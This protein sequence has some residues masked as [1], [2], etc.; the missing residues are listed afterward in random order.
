MFINGCTFDNNT[1]NFGGAIRYG[2]AG[3]LAV[4]NT[5]FSANT[6]TAAGGAMQ[7]SIVA[8]PA[9]LSDTVVS[10]HTK[11]QQ[12]VNAVQLM[13]IAMVNTVN[14]VLLN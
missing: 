5:E 8:K 3:T 13:L 12:S 14:Y 10:V 11:R 7:S 2:P 4:D 9:V 1:A 6:A